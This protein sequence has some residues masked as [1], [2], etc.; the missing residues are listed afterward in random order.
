MNQKVDRTY[1]NSGDDS[2]VKVTLR[3]GF[4]ARFWVTGLS[5]AEYIRRTKEIKKLERGDA[6]L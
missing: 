4:S 6:S 2:E 3:C 1:E 5:D